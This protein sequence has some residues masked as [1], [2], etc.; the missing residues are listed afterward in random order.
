[1]QDD[2]DHPAQLRQAILDQVA[3][4]YAAAHANR[5]FSP[6]ETRV[7]YAG[8]VYDAQEMVNM[9]DSVLEFYLTAG[10]WSQQFERKLARFLG[11]R[12]VLP[13][14]S[15]S[16]ANL[17]AI[18][19]LCSRQL[20][21]PLQ[22]GD[23]VI[24]PATSFPTTI[25]PVI[26]NNLVPVFVDNCHA[27]LNLDVSQLEAALSPRTRALFF[28]HTLGN[29]ANMDVIMPFVQKHDLYLVEDACDALGTRWDGRMVGTFGIMGT[30]STYPAHHITMG[31]G[32][33]VFTNRPKIATIA[34]AIRDW[35]RD[36]W[37]GYTSPPNGQCGRRFDHEIPGVPGCY[38]HKYIYSEIGYNLKLTDPQAA[39]GVAQLDKL[40]DFITA[41][42]RNFARL[43]ERLR[44]Y[45]EWL[46]L[47]AWHPKA[48]VS[49]FAFP[50]T[51]RPEAPFSRNALTR[52]LELHGVETRLIFAGNILR[53]PAYQHITH[54]VVGDL[55]VADDIMRNGFFVGVYPGIDQPRLDYMADMF[56][57]FMREEAA[58]P[59]RD[60]PSTP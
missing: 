24:V 19:T 47:P 27:D 56:D 52:W 9:V 25:N 37:C 2:P 33:A 29:P 30:L 31:E 35:G 6:G 22:P 20:D 32:G 10:R 41:R 46:R 4:Y 26:Q 28:A 23:E 12:E 14:N 13:V 17:V 54:R 44:P 16:S 21:N 1:M 5:P 8:R 18:T 49:W 11:V 45:E 53:Q 36:C 40:P 15:G 57:R 38:D 39:V 3:A 43:Y 50:L 34:R 51:V 59:R 42:K 60:R 58:P 48:D 55:A 7:Q